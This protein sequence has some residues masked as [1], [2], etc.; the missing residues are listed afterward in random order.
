MTRVAIC[1]LDEID[2]AFSGDCDLISKILHYGQCENDVIQD[3]GV[4]YID[5]HV[6]LKQNYKKTE[7]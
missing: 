2:D 6:Y 5:E 1:A 3:F 4:W 7:H